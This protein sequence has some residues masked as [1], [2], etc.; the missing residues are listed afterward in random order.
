MYVTMNNQN[1]TIIDYGMGNLMS[2]Q[3][4]FSYFGAKVITTSD[5]EVIL[6]S[7]KIV[8]PGVGAFAKAM[9]ELNH[10]NLTEA[11]NEAVD[12]GSLILGICLGMQLLLDESQEFGISKGLGLISGEVVPIS[13]KSKLGKKLTIPHIGWSAL[14]K[15]QF[16]PNWDSTLLEEFIE[17]EEVYFVHSFMARLKNK[18]QCLANCNYEDV[19]IPAFLEKNNIFGCQFHPEKSGLVGTKIIKS[20]IKY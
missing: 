18:K 15:N 4:S 20:F 8:L 7:D 14:Q 3:R 16:N 9:E 13:S 6:K 5:P 19:L 1:I 2:V 10:R 12:K 11:I 17:S